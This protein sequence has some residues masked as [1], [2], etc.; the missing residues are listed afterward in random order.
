MKNENKLP[1]DLIDLCAGEVR[2]SP[3]ALQ[4]LAQIAVCRS[5]VDCE[6]YLREVQDRFAYGKGGARDALAAECAAKELSRA[7]AD[8]ALAVRF[9]SA[10]DSLAAGE[11]ETL[12][13]HPQ[14]VT[15]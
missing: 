7:A 8:L 13:V 3:Q 6:N 14:K 11:R 4:K 10:F 2:V 1:I 5:R 12:A 9:L 15:N